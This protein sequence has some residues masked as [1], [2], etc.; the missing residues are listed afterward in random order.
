M[1]IFGNTLRFG[2]H[3]GQQH[4]D[5]P[6]YLRLWKDAE[7]LGYDWASVFDHFLPIQTDPDGPCF[8]GPTVL[9]A[10]AASTSKLRCGIIVTGVTYRH[11]TLLANIASTLDHVSAGRFEL[12]MGA[13]WYE[14]EHQQYGIPFPR[15]GE[16]MDM[17]EEAVPI[18]KSLLTQPTTTFEGRHYQV[19]D[20]RCEPKPL[21]PG[22]V[23]I[24]IGGGGEKRTLKI[25]AQHADGWNFFLGAPDEYRRKLEVLEGHC[26]TFDRD[27]ADIRKGLIFQ[28]ILDEDRSKAQDRAPRSDSVTQ[29]ALGE[30]AI[31]GTPEDMVARLRPFVDMGV[32]DFL[33][34]A[35]PPVDPKTLEL[36]ATRV[37][38]ALRG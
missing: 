12:G 1:Q 36:I 19:R 27:P 4:T 20:A 11:P 38:P 34:M 3:P 24:W 10:L 29:V 31:V 22:G 15:I 13:A 32:G 18:V 2:I 9:A 14:L 16:R 23:P 8:E 17:L 26:R 7:E 28:A 6:S 30:H 25:V 37:A 35:R 33:L 21:Q 5:Y